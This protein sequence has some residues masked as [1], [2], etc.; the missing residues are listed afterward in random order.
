MTQELFFDWLRRLSQYVGRFSGRKIL[1]FI[2]NCSAHGSK[3]NLSVFDYLRIEFLPPNT[4]SKVQ[5]L[6]AGIIALVKRKYKRRLL[7]RIFENIEARQ[8]YIYNVHVLNAIKWTYEEWN[9]CPKKVILNCFMHCFKHSESY[10]E[11]QQE[12]DEDCLESMQR[13]AAENNVQYIRVG[14]E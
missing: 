1:L 7:L 12:N 5:P 2:E 6:D 8:K 3:D 9:A 13:D 14:L 10:I 11:E 4:T